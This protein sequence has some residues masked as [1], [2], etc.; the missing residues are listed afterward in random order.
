MADTTWEL[1]S[2]L[3]PSLVANYEA[4]IQHEIQKTSFSTG[5][6]TVHTFSTNPVEPSVKRRKTDSSEHHLSSSG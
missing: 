2:I 4:G 3:P 5:G 1:D 6:Q